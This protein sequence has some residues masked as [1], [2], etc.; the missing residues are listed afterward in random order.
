MHA[1]RAFGTLLHSLQPPPPSPYSRPSL[2]DG[3][4]GL[5]RVLRVHITD[6]C[7]QVLRVASSGQVQ[8]GLFRGVSACPP[9]DV[10]RV[11]GTQGVCYG[12]GLGVFIGD[13]TE[14]PGNL[15]C[16]TQRFQCV[17]PALQL[18]CGDSGEKYE[19]ADHCQ[20]WSVWDTRH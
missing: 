7:G 9:G 18:G 6:G 8:G 13:Y 3:L 16:V 15:G 14:D 11:W 20:Y 12:W 17:L 2:P 10:L 1:L 4:S 5:L 19:A